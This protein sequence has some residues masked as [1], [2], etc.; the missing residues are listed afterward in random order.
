MST[1]QS[2]TDKQELPK[3]IVDHLRRYAESP[4]KGHLWDGTAVGG[5]ADTPTLLLTTTGRKSGRQL[6][7]PLIYGKDGDRYVIVASKGGAPQHPAWYLN[8][9]DNPQVGVQVI[10][11]RFPAV[12]R[13]ATGE[14]RERLWK[15]MSAIYPPYP[16]YQQRTDRE[17][18]VVVLERKR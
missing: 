7:M 5:Y 14:E 11:D 2:A 4:E 6:T 17:I 16:S 1:N 10:A 15:M 12:A 18:P 8:L 13:T 3:W 9:H